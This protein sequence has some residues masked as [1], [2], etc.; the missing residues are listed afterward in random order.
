MT[1]PMVNYKYVFQIKYTEAILSHSTRKLLWFEITKMLTAVKNNFIVL[2]IIIFDT[3]SF[4]VV[5]RTS[6]GRAETYADRV[7]H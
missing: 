2:F 1:F 5:Y 7:M 4:P 3:F 6:D